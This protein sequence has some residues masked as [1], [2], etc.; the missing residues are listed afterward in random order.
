M[1]LT[2]KFHLEDQGMNKKE[3]NEFEIKYAEIDPP[4][5]GTKESKDDPISLDTQP[6]A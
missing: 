5:E 4:K 2:K 3:L 1:A 6:Q